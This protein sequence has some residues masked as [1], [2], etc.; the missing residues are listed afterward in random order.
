MT[1]PAR[2]AA[3]LLGDRED[4]EAVARVVAD[5]LARKNEWAGNFPGE[6]ARRSASLGLTRDEGLAALRFLLDLSGAPEAERWLA[7]GET[8]S[9]EQPAP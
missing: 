4:P 8:R 3:D 1:T 6:L 9:V 5:S 2:T 7:E